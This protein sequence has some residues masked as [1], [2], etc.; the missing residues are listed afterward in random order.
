MDHRTD[1]EQVAQRC[2]KRYANKGMATYDDLYQEAWIHALPAYRDYWVRA[3]NHT[4]EGLRGWLYQALCRRL[5]MA[6]RRVSSPVSFPKKNLPPLIRDG[7]VRVGEE[8]IPGRSA[9]YENSAII[10]TVLEK[11]ERDYPLGAIALKQDQAATDLAAKLTKY[12]LTTEI[13]RQMRAAKAALARNLPD[14]DDNH[15]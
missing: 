13:R 15:S 4:R 14:H 3:S 6:G 2:A 1:V 10:Q 11:V 5:S 9:N 8:H 7:V 12:Q